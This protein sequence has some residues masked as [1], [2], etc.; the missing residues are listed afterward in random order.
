MNLESFQEVAQTLLQNGSFDRAEDI[1]IYLTTLCPTNTSGWIGLGM[2]RYYKGN[3][4]QASYAFDIAIKLGDVSI[5][6]LLWKIECFLKIGLL[7]EAKHLL[8]HVEAL[9]MPMTLSNAQHVKQ[10]QHIIGSI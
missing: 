8:H 9:K 3:T 7:E 4:D 6:P 5:T 1:Y 2:A 10:L